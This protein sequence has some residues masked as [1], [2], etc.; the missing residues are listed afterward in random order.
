MN[1]LP[2]SANIQ[3]RHIERQKPFDTAAEAFPF[4][5]TTGFDP[6]DLAYC[7]RINC[8]RQLD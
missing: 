6:M 2:A 7:L 5:A 3:R 1:A 8:K 4:K